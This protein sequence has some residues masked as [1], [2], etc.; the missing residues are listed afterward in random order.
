M[1][2]CTWLCNIKEKGFKPLKSIH[3]VL[4][5]SIINNILPSLLSLISCKVIIKFN[6]R[7]RIIK[8]KVDKL[9]NWTSEHL[10]IYVQRLQYQTN[11]YRIPHAW[12]ELDRRILHA[13]MQ[14]CHGSTY[15]YKKGLLRNNNFKD[16]NRYLRKIYTFFEQLFW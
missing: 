14:S 1:H 4:E 8:A 11:C 2:S 13:S 6:T 9:D 10:E 15:Q 3:E 7:K 12:F 16:K 5:K